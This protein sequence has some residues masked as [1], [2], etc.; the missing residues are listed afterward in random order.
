MR[1]DSSVR[2]K[3]ESDSDRKVRMLGAPEVGH[4]PQTGPEGGVP[5]ITSMT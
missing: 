5:R 1:T 4:L 3:N 2:S